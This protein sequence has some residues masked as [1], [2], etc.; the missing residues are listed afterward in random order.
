VEEEE[1]RRKVSWE[2][3]EEREREI[4]WARHASEPQ[5][6]K[7]DQWRFGKAGDWDD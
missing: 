3:E 1:R 6:G 4:S 2:E 7:G 5:D